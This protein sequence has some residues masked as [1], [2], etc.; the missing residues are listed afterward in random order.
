[1][2]IARW[3]WLSIVTNACRCAGAR[4]GAASWCLIRPEMIHSYTIFLAIWIVN[5]PVPLGRD[6]AA[7]A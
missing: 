3:A 5:A 6:A 4:N 7:H 1:M 2:M